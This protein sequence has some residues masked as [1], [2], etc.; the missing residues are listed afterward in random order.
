MKRENLPE[1]HG[2][3]NCGRAAKFSAWAYA[4]W[5][6]QIVHTCECG[7]RS[8]L[9]RGVPVSL[10]PPKEFHLASGNLLDAYGERYGI[11]RIG[12]PVQ[13]GFNCKGDVR[14]TYLPPDFPTVGYVEP[15]ADYRARILA[16]VSTNYPSPILK[17]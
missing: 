16:E 10:N 1:S 5:N 14:P 7:A 17:G 13:F 8:T 2:C 6:E 12:R 11:I 4:H 9:L 3:A 15:D